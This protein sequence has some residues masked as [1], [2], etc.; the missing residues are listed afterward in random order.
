KPILD[1]D[2]DVYWRT[3]EVN[4]HGLFNMA[5]AFLAMQLSTRANGGSCIM[6]NLA[7]SSA[8]TARPAGGSYRSSKL[9]ILRWTESLQ[10]EYG[11]REIHELVRY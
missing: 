4:V 3:W 8:L 9:A 7:S 2:P 6:I 10:L 5:R 1:S 11:D